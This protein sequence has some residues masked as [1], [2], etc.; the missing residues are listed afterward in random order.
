M[1]IVS[2]LLPVRNAA[3]WIDAAL[4]S[5]ARQTMR[6]FEIVA[7]DDGSTDETPARLA[8][9]AEREPRLVLVRASSRGL[10]QALEIARG[11]ARAPYLA[12]HDA[13]DL[14]HP[15]RLEV[16]LAFLAAHPRV[17]V[18]GCR[19]RL[20]PASFV[21][22]G[23]RRWVRWHNALLDH[24]AMA[25]DVLVESPL[26]HGTAM[27]RR[28]AL[29]KVGGWRERDW[30]EDV[31]L[32]I[33]MLAAGSRLGKCPETLYAWRQHAASA[34]RT[35]PRYGTDRFLALKLDALVHGLL[36]GE[37]VATLVGVGAS[38][39]R[40]ARA[41]A[42]TVEAPSVARL[43]ASRPSGPSVARLVPPIV[44][45]FGAQAARER[46]RAALLTRG[47]A[48]GREFVFVA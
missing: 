47:L 28:R 24:D 34:T 48:E 43:E 40:W 16:Q 18:V 33:R 14:S 13:D 3:P 46:W 20:F 22:D 1:P 6:D 42:D 15:R 8:R 17:D 19:V 23:M 37:R 35:D 32:W 39:A 38:L 25:R 29:E 21:R 44:L 36:S 45:V 31:D 26:A 9:A 30:P 5:L 2:V 27:F 10:P 7:V 11:V 12:R 4:A 41:L